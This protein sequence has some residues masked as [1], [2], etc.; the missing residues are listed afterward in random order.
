MT[1]TIAGSIVSQRSGNGCE[2]KYFRP[3]LLALHSHTPFSAQASRFGP[4][5]ALPPELVL[6][7]SKFPPLPFLHHGELS[8]LLPAIPTTVPT[9]EDRGGPLRY[10]I[11]LIV[12]CVLTRRKLCE[13]NPWRCVSVAQSP[14]SVPIAVILHNNEFLIRTWTIVCGIPY[15]PRL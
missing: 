7:L 5:W 15:P 2:G 11:I 8:R 13:P 12:F 14:L 9:N 6:P 1:C 3:T 10:E 4:L